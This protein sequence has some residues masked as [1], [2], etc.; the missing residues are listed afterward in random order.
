MV[1]CY[2]GIL[3]YSWQVR[4]IKAVLYP[5]CD[6]ILFRRVSLGF[7]LIYW[8]MKTI[9]GNCVCLCDS[10]S[11]WRVRLGNGQRKSARGSCVLPALWFAPGGPCS[12]LD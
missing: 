12:W 11:V 1:C 8:N 2:A 10:V 7:G 9:K 4:L 5:A 6:L 3:S